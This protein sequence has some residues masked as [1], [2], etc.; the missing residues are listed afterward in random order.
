M[1]LCCY[2][3]AFP[4]LGT[5]IVLYANHEHGLLMNHDSSGADLLNNY[6]IMS[7]TI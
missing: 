3:Y 5:V 7:I 4:L 2:Q 1:Y 6:E